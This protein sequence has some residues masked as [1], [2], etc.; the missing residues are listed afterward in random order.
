MKICSSLIKFW[1][2]RWE[3]IDNNPRWQRY[4]FVGLAL[5]YGVIAAIALVQLVRIQRRVPEYGWTTQKVFHL[6]NA[7]VCLLR[8]AV[9]ASRDKVSLAAKP[10]ATGSSCMPKSMVCVKKCVPVARLW[11]TL[12]SEVHTPVPF[13]APHALS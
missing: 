7:F 2:C 3:D 6:L 10:F 5:G 4:T 12:G 11:W 1:G 9:F 13:L 8:C